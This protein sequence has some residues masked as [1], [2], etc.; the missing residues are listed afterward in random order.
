MSSLSSSSPSSK[1]LGDRALF[2]Y[3]WRSMSSSKDFGEMLPPWSESLSLLSPS[4]SSSSISSDSEVKK[5]SYYYRSSSA[6]SP[7]SW[8][9]SRP[10]SSSLPKSAR[11]ST[12]SGAYGLLVSAPIFDCIIRGEESSSIASLS[13]NESGTVTYG[14]DN[15]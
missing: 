13:L 4:I 15:F 14:L 11:R 1:S 10:S 6:Y 12:F 5:S 3:F 2:Y 9:S 7:V 8:T